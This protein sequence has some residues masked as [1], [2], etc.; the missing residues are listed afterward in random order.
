[1]HVFTQRLLH[2]A[3]T[4]STNR[5]IKSYVNVYTRFCNSVACSPFPVE[6]DFLIRYVAHLTLSGRTFGTIIN[7][8]SSIKHVNQPL[9]FDRVWDTVIV[10]ASI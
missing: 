8:L 4:E 1:M 2:H 3:F 7:H 5:N 9:G 6:V 10:I